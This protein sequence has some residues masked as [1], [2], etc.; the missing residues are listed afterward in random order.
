MHFEIHN[1]ALHEDKAYSNLAN[2]LK[3]Y[4]FA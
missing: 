3:S 4:Y 1:K 2:L